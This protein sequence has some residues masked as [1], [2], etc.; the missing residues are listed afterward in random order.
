MNRAA[1]VA[2]MANISKAITDMQLENGQ[3]TIIDGFMHAQAVPTFHKGKGIFKQRISN[4]QLREMARNMGV[5]L[6]YKDAQ[7]LMEREEE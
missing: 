5:S 2:M 7:T 6:K 3:G 1:R 4:K